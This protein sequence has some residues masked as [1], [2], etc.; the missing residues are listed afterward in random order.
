[1]LLSPA[2]AL[3]DGKMENSP[4]CMGY[5]HPYVGT[6]DCCTLDSSLQVESY[7]V[8]TSEESRNQHSVQVINIPMHDY[9]KHNHVKKT[10]IKNKQCAC[11]SYQRY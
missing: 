11:V 7:E 3:V 4:G 10:H 2:H 8:Q 6:V 5:T 9:H 1:M